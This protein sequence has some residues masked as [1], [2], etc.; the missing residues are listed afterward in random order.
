M[1]E[2]LGIHRSRREKKT[3]KGFGNVSIKSSRLPRALR[4]EKKPGSNRY[5]SDDDS[6]SGRTIRYF[7]GIYDKE[8]FKECHQ[9][10]GPCI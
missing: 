2:V 8:S 5:I 1:I 6:T 9:A 4:K 10:E 7:I 3:D